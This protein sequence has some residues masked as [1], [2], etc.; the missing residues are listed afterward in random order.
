[1]E[2]DTWKFRLFCGLFGVFIIS[3]FFAF[4]ELRFVIWG[5]TTQA[6]LID[7]YE[8]KDINVRGDSEPALV[9]HYTFQ[10]PV[11]GL[12]MRDENDLLPIDW[13]RPGGETVQVQYIPGVKNASRLVGHRRMGSVVFCLASLAIVSGFILKLAREAKEPVPRPRPRSLQS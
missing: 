2:T 9:V 11:E 8:G 13:R 1:M 3:L 12:G 7:V 4:R 5:M 10:D 6:R